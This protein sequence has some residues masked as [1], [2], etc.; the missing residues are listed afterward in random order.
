MK[1]AEAAQIA[2]GVRPIDVERADQWRTSCCHA[3]RYQMKVLYDM[4]LK[5]TTMISGKKEGARKIDKGRIGCCA[6]LCSQTANATKKIMAVIKR[7]ISY[8]EPHPA[9]GAWLEGLAEMLGYEVQNTY[10]QTKLKMIRPLMPIL[11]PIQSIDSDLLVG[12]SGG[13]RSARLP[14]TTNPSMALIADCQL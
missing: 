13:S 2:M 3:T 8:G 4:K 11:E 5:R 10:F 14:K 1:A 7:A 6:T 9:V 12:S